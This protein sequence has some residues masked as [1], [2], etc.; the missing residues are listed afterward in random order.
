MEANVLDMF[1]LDGKIALITGGSR[2]LCF[3]MVIGLAQAGAITIISSRKQSDCEK[4]AAE[5]Y[6]QT[7]KESTGI[8]VDVSREESVKK[9]FKAVIKKYN[10]LDILVNGAGINI[11]HPIEEY[12]ASDCKRVFDTNI[13]GM[14]LCC[15]EAV[16][17]MK[18]QRAGSIINIGSALGEVGMP[19]RSAYCASK[20]AVMGITRVVALELAPAGAR[21]NA[22]C[23]GPFLTEINKALLQDPKKVKDLIGRTAFKRWADLKEIR[24]T[25]VFLAS[26]ASSYMTGS[27][28]YVDGGWTAQ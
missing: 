5:I 10:R 19:Q 16:V 11:R 20:S 22:I 12:P 9:L 21:C 28:V 14:W 24:G 26:D 8:A 15:K 23:P 7:G 1:R 2:G 3:S 25:V 6:S 18:K 4:A 17:I 27:A 13:Y